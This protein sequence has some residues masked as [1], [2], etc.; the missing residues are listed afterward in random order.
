MLVSGSRGHAEELRDDVAGA[1]K[2]MGLRLSVEKTRI[3]HIDEGL[4]FL[5]WRIPRHPKQGADRQ[6]IYTC[7][8]RKSVRSATAKVKELTRRQNVGLALTFL[9]RRL[10]SALRG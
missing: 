8:A 1:L 2:P 9:L 5:G 6:Y 4:D 3:T 7:P 10:N